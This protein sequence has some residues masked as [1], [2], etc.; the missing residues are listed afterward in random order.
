MIYQWT[1]LQGVYLLFI[2]VE[3]FQIGM[4][5]FKVIKFEFESFSETIFLILLS[6]RMWASKLV[7]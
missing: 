7:T 3:I 1:D 2:A 5:H 4:F 6:F